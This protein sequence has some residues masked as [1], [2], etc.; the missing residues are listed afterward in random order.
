M[1]GT[2]A[3]LAIATLLF[4][5]HHIL[6][7]RHFIKDPI[8][9]AIG[10]RGNMIL[11]SIISIV[12]LVWM[13]WAYVE[14]PNEAIWPTTD[15]ARYVAL[16]VNPLAMIL[17][18]CGYFSPSP[19]ALIGHGFRLEQK[20]SWITRVSRHP[21][22]CAVALLCLTHIAVNGDLASII[23]FGSNAFLAAAGMPIMDSKKQEKWGE[24]T[25]EAFAAQTSAV[26]FVAILTNRTE[27]SFSEIPWVPV[28]AGLGIYFAFLFGHQM[29]FGVAALLG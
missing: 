22:M 11:Y 20:L 25:W 16:L 29:L 10:K 13:I 19:T 2:F 28:L 3:D 23:L 17:L 4:L 24:E 14:A 7:A 26:P 15:L 5:G 12:L 6:T 27:V 1:T 8:V 9:G 21:V 18:A